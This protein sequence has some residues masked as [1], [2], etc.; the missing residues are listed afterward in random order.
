FLTVRLG[1][2][3]EAM[4]GLHHQGLDIDL[5]TVSSALEQAGRLEET[6]G[7]A[8]ITGLINN[9]PTAMHAASYGAGVTDAAGRRSALDAL[10]TIANA[11]HSPDHQLDTLL[12]DGQQSLL[13]VQATYVP[14]QV[15]STADVV[16]QLMEMLSGSGQAMHAGYHKLADAT[17]HQIARSRY[18]SIIGHPGVGKS[19]WLAHM[20]LALARQAPGVY[21]TNEMPH[22]ELLLLLAQAN[23][24]FE[25]RDNAG[26]RQGVTKAQLLSN[27]QAAYEAVINAAADMAKLPIDWLH[28]M[29]LDNLIAHVKRLKQ[30]GVPIQWVLIDSLPKMPDVQVSDGFG[31]L[32]KAHN[33]LAGLAMM[34]D[35]LVISISNVSK[36]GTDNRPTL[37]DIQ[38]KD[39]GYSMDGCLGLFRPDPGEKQLYELEV[40]VLKNRYGS[41]GKRFTLQVDAPLSSSKTYWQSLISKRGTLIWRMR[42]R[43]TR[44]WCITYATSTPITC[45]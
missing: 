30:E 45:P 4:M 1:W 24:D 43:R 15:N 36:A 35:L 2:I 11:L 16:D 18:W 8:Y 26:P 32:S 14:Q 17:D 22:P 21:L 20:G 40:D 29:P 23:A 7:A 10:S 5:L 28:N 19:T 37:A 9:L 42:L 12:S 33:K 44:R 39:G 13:D 41:K 27:N 25:W 31:A 3:W 34:D 6:G 38:F